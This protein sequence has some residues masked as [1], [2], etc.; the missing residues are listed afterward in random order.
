MINEFSMSVLFV[1]DKDFP[2]A[3]LGIDDAAAISGAD[4]DYIVVIC[5]LSTGAL[6]SWLAGRLLSRLQSFFQC[7]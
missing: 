5:A 2:R 7:M 4:V 3:P 1:P 6:S